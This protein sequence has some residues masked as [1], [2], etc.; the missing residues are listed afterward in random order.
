M[1]K[2]ELVKAIVRYTPATIYKQKFIC[3]TKKNE[4]SRRYLLMQKAE[5]HNPQNIGKWECAGGI[6][7]PGETSRK[8]IERELTEEL[9]G[10]EY[11]IFKKLPTIRNCAVYLID[12]ASLNVHLSREH[13]DYR[14]L[15]AEDVQKQDLV[16]YAYLLLEFF[17]NPKKY[18]D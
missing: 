6:L 14:W 3:G 9:P 8:A 18:L 1:S 15:K 5:D 12:A 7:K 2:I 10:L 16:A 11:R 17:N 4:D 13:S